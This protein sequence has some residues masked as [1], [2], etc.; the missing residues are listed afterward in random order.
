MECSIKR[1]PLGQYSQTVVQA[2]LEVRQQLPDPQDIAQVNIRTLERAVQIMAGE[3]MT[4]RRI[5]ALLDLL[6]RLDEQPH[7]SQLI[8]LLRI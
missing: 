6:W 7:L 5:D 1:F 2:A 8:R 4:A 3:H